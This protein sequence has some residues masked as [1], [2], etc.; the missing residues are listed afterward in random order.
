MATKAE[1]S[2]MLDQVSDCLDEVLD[3]RLSREEIVAK[4]AELNDE[5][6]VGDDEVDDEDDEDIAEGVGK[7]DAT[8]LVSLAAAN[9]DDLAAAVDVPDLQASDFRYPKSGSVES[10]PHRALSFFG[11]SR[12]RLTSSFVRM[13]GS[14]C[15]NRG[16]EMRSTSFLRFRVLR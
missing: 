10:G 14:F 11:A 6:F 4:I 5:L 2:A 15:S 16:R 3:P 1:M 12:S 7:H 8:V 9:V 13:T